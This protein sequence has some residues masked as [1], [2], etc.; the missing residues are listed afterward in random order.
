[1][2]LIKQLELCEKE[3]SN[4]HDQVR[5]TYSIIKSSDGTKLIQLDTY[6]TSSRK[7]PD[8]VSQTV[9]FNHDSAV[10]LLKLIRETYPDLA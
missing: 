6:G 1:M 4:I 5:C 3:H 10:Q 7:I 2:A 9:Q 8:K